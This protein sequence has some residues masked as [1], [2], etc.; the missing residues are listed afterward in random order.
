MI[1]DYK[2]FDLFG[3]QFLQK[4]VL[5]PPFEYT[6]P[7]AEQACFLYMLNGEM[8]YQSA[9]NQIDIPTRHALLLNCINSG[10][11]IR[12]TNAK[13]KGEIVI[14]TFHPEILKRIYEREL[15]LV[16]QASNKVTNQSGSGISND[17][18]IQKYIEG[19]LFYFE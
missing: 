15:P 14:V 4:I 2:K 10:K 6:F 12:E 19:L 5:T 1:I 3:R 13:G 16:F 9:D 17:F 11:K 7:Q 8:Q 18:L